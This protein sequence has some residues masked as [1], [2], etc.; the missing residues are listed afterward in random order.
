MNE[1]LSDGV[2]L[3]GT[4]ASAVWKWQSKVR[5]SGMGKPCSGI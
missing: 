1:I 3:T 2:V 5:L 4:F